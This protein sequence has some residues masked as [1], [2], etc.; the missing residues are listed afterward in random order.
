MLP[1]FVGDGVQ[2]LGIH[3]IVHPATAEPP[4]LALNAPEQALRSQLP[5]AMEPQARRT[6]ALLPVTDIPDSN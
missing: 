5:I 6:S 2:L 3:P 4:G 1:E